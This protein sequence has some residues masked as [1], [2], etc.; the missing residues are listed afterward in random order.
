MAKKKRGIDFKYI[1]RDKISKEIKEGVLNGPSKEEVEKHLIQNGFTPVQVQEAKAT[2]LEMEISLGKKKIKQR[3]LAVWCRQ[4]AIMFNAG[5]DLKTSLNILSKQTENESLKEITEDITTDVEGGMGFADALNEHPEVFP[6]LMVKMVRA[7]EVGGFLDATLSQISKDIDADVAL[8]AKIKSALTYPVVVLIMAVIICIA[9]L[10]FVVPTFENMFASMGGELPAA[11]QLLVNL[12][13][14]LKVGGIPLA[15]G[16]IVFGAWWK[17]NKNREGIKNFVDPIKLG[18]PVFGGLMTKL[19]IARFTR[20]LS[21]LQRA[22]VTLIDSLAIVGGTVGNVVVEKALK[23]VSQGVQRGEPVSANLAQHD[24]F[25]PM[26]IQMVAVGEDA[27]KLEEMLMKISEDYEEQVNT[28][29]EQLASLIEPLMIGF[30][31]IVVG[32]MVIAL[33]M[34]I[35]SIYDVIQ[36]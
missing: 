2:G 33:Y 21:T 30:L 13:D 27:G 10:I 11:T 22:G 19:V 9:M 15:I 16:F 36:A 29:T 3:D 28:T 34:P 32:G 14:F 24:V 25:P 1:A 8:R 6:D 4:I 31:G 7:A 12:S 5:I 18:M 23:E 35:F 20:N 17:K 26:V